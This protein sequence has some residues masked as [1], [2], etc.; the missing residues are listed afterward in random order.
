VTP[1]DIATIYPRTTSRPFYRKL[2][3]LDVRVRPDVPMLGGGVFKS[4][5]GGA[6]WT[7][8][9]SGLTNRP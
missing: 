9:D 4:T 5:N 8:I 3:N 2:L 1:S 6:S 7:A